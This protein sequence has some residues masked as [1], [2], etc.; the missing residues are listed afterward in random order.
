MAETR[1][2]GTGQALGPAV[3]DGVYCFEVEPGV[4]IDTRPG[5]AQDEDGVDVSLIEMMLRLTPRER[6]RMVGQWNA[7]AEAGTAVRGDD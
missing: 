5:A 4:V 7:L 2:D 1:E 3:A 6:L